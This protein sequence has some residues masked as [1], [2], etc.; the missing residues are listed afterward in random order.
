MGG[1]V[2]Q[3]YWFSTDA[4]HYLVK[5]DANS[6]IGELTA[7]RQKNSLTPNEYREDELGFTLAA[8]AGPLR[9]CEKTASMAV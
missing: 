3:M 5:F 7:I 8:P 2:N 6:V 4:R 1:I 9:R